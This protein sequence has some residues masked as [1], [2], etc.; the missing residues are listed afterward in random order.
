M[1]DSTPGLAKENS[2]VSNGVRCLTTRGV[3]K[4]TSGRGLGTARAS[5]GLS[6][7]RWRMVFPSRLLARGEKDTSLMVAHVLIHM[8]IPSPLLA[9][10]KE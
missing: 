4:P 1:C 9:Q 2:T 5:V 7:D 8:V 10:R 6:R 3:S